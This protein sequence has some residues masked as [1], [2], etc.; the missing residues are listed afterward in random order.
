MILRFDNTEYLQLV[1]DMLDAKQIIFMKILVYGNFGHTSLFVLICS[2]LLV[3]SSHFLGPTFG[4]QKLFFHFSVTFVSNR[5][6]MH[7]LK[8]V[9]L[10]RD[11]M[12]AHNVGPL[13]GLMDVPV[14][15]RIVSV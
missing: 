15:A 2:L 14:P 11:I 4:R 13:D 12:S 5:Y 8:R 10:H 6:V 1:H 3:L 7:S 9:V